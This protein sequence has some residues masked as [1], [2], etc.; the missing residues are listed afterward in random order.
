MTQNLLKTLPCHPFWK[1]SI[2]IYSQ[3]EIEKTLLVLQQE[4]GLNINILLFCC[5]YSFSD[6]GKLGRGQLKKMLLNIQPWH[7]RIVLPLRRIR[8]QL[9]SQLHHSW[10]AG[11]RKEICEHELFAEQVEQYIL[12]DDFVYEAKPIRTTLQKITDICKSIATYCHLVHVFLDIR[13]CESISRLLGT[14]FSKIDREDIL[15]YCMDHLVVKELH[16][17]NLSAQLALDL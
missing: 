9:K 13:D 14:I 5:W 7:E 2:K 4:R 3:P 1:F 11:V 17:M 8:Q 6:Q 12:L 10:V 16:T 15:R